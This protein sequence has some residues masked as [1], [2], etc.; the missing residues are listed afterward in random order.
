MIRCTMSTP[1]DW[2]TEEEEAMFVLDMTTTQRIKPNKKCSRTTAQ[3]HAVISLAPHQV[4]AAV[5]PVSRAAS[6]TRDLR[7]CK[8]STGRVHLQ[9]MSRP[10]N[11]R[12]QR[13]LDV[14][15]S[16]LDP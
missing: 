12:L 2:A 11:D 4:S 5:F 16:T 15:G 7:S 13:S 9:M 6:V 8:A 10:P 1:A 14:H 3:S